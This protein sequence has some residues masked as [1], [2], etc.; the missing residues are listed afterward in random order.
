MKII[1]MAS[2]PNYNPS[3][4]NNRDEWSLYDVSRG[5]V[6]L[7]T[8][9]NKPNCIEHQAM[10][11]VSQDKTIWRCLT[12]SRSCFDLDKIEKNNCN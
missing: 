3:T 9:W 10:N 11:C 7:D 8:Q 6:Y 1:D 12:C 4:N 2:S 5:E